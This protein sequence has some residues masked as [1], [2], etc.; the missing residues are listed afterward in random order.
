MELE[1]P[2]WTHDVVYRKKSSLYLCPLKKA[3]E[4]KTNSVS[5]GMFSTYITVSKYH[6]PL[7]WIRVP[8]WTSQ[9]YMLG[10]TFSW[11]ARN[12]LLYKR[13]GSCYQRLLES[14]SKGLRSKPEKASQITNGPIW[15]WT[16][17]TTR[18]LKYIKCAKIH[19]F[20]LTL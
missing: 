18:R 20:L 8:W 3:K 1:V 17:A 11:W 14:M 19:E 10:R 9:F 4:T 7:K 2:T 6:F 15:R 5:M 13:G 16:R 12:I